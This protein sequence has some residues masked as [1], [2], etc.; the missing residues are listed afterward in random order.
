MQCRQRKRSTRP[1]FLAFAAA[2]SFVGFSAS[3]SARLQKRQPFAAM[4][5]MTALAAEE[6]LLNSLP[7]SSR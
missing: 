2:F 3:S 5:P 6:G 4:P 7:S 1:F